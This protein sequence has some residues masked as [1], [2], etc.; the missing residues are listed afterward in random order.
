MESLLLSTVFAAAAGIES[1]PATYLTNL[2]LND[3]DSQAFAPAAGVLSSRAAL[4]RSNAGMKIF[5]WKNRKEL[6]LEEKLAPITLDNLR[7]AP[8]ST[9]RKMRKGRGKGSGWGT[10]CGF[11]NDGQKARSG[12]PQKPGF[13]G[14]QTPLYR[15]LPKYVGRPIGTGAR[16][17][18]TSRAWNLIKTTDLN[19]LDDG[20]T[21]NF[22]SLYLGGHV[23]KTKHK[24]H[25]V[26]RGREPL[27]VKGL[28][29]QAHAFTTPAMKEIVA[30]GGT[31]QF[32]KIRNSAKNRG[33]R[34][35]P[36]IETRTT[37]KYNPNLISKEQRLIER[38]E[39]FNKLREEGDTDVES[40]MSLSKRLD[41]M[42][43]LRRRR[44]DESKYWEKG[45][46]SYSGDQKLFDMMMQE[47]RL[48]KVNAEK[49]EER[50]KEAEGE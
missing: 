35:D 5:D 26:V 38:R 21:V 3:P 41:A 19:K 31:L 49:E 45:E 14:G 1:N 27:K 37:V 43:R 40:K 44:R 23:H 6:T 15:R 10:T 13:E 34:P 30:N 50:R 39:V 29:I 25:K 48:Y 20:A 16:Y 36:V 12:R 33:K 11:G 17:R 47:D 4:P 18:K 7:K 22:Q 9:K 24:I 28:T 46:T 2:L 8:G 32:L 42:K